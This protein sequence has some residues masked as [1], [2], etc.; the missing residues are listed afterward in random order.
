MK[1]KLAMEMQLVPVPPDSIPTIDTESDIFVAQTTMSLGHWSRVLATYLSVRGLARTATFTGCAILHNLVQG[2][3]K[4]LVKGTLQH[5][6][7]T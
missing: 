6:M 4:D 5:K 2:L 7:P 3:G 1:D